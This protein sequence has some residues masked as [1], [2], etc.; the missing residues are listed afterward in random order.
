MKRFLI[1]FISFSIPIVIILI[2]I[3]LL[4][5]S[6]TYSVSVKKK[7][8][9]E[10]N[11]KIKIIALGSSH[12]ER[13]INPEF[14]NHK[15]LN[16]GNS[17]QRI[18]ENFELFRHFNP[19]LNSLKLVIIEVSYD[20]LE[21]DKKFTSPLI[22]HLNL[23]FYNTNTFQ[24]PLKLK[25]SLHYFADPDF[26]SHKLNQYLKGEMELKYNKFG[27]DTTKFDGSYQA[28][29]HIDSL[30]LDKDI[31][32]ENVQNKIA[33]EKNTNTLR[34]LITICQ[35]G[36][37]NVLIY[38]P[39]THSRYNQLRIENIIRRRDS[40]LNLLKNQF[41]DLKVLDL[42]SNPDF[43]T[44][45]FYNGDHLNPKGAKK[46]TLRLNEFIENNYDL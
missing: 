4:L 42:E 18:P 36:G 11:E 9:N 41:P 44:T 7:F 20:W 30:I 23:M 45:D 34:K 13:G 40:V 26:F 6:F 31:Y 1:Q 10:H 33:L 38:N 39:P 27:F 43:I 32:I 12:Y 5:K 28:V 21:R 2:T 22:D 37:L 24:R 8:F 46:A 25:D 29:N 15:T 17:S 19:K 3:E 35:D 16:L 14:L